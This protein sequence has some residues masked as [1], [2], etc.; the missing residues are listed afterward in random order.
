MYYPSTPGSPSHL[1]CKA[2]KSGILHRPVKSGKVCGKQRGKSRLQGE[3][4]LSRTSKGNRC[5]SNS[6]ITKL[7]K[8]NPNI[9]VSIGKEF[10]STPY[11]GHLYF[12]HSQA[13]GGSF[14]HPSNLQ[15]A[16]MISEHFHLLQ[17]QRLRLQPH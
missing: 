10:T 2:L 8:K 17:Q 12:I 16:L 14:S 4:V 7:K 6:V 13:L 11:F 9:L 3:K 5:L 15:R 1:H